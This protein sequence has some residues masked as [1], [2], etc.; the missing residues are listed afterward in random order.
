[1]WRLTS[2]DEGVV[3]TGE[4]CPE[5]GVMELVARMGFTPD[6]VQ[7][8][9]LGLLDEDVVVNCT[10]Q[11]GK[12]TLGAVV[13]VV[14]A[15]REPGSTVLVMGPT[16]GQ[17]GELVEKAKEFA[18]TLAGGV[19]LPRDH[20]RKCSVVLPN[21]SRIVG[22]P[23]KPGNI[24]CYTASLLLVD[25][26]AFVR[27]DRAY[28]SVRPALAV[29]NGQ[30]WLLSTSG[31]MEGFFYRTW[32]GE[33]DGWKRVQVKAGDCPRLHPD[34]LAKERRDKTPEAYAREYECVFGS[35]EGAIFEEDLLE[36]AMLR[37]GSG[38]DVS[39]RGERVEF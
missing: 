23:P 21:R 7:A 29:R 36:R 15:W 22:L 30:T 16:E 13:A 20:S 2:P 31:A 1:M 9:V 37:E 3:A 4:V 28:E 14:R 26:A 38:R 39:W 17:A 33:G 12:S 11:W 34:F 10:R 19:R 8:E 27:D 32:S 18:E 6:A 5:E 24:R 35:D 25:E